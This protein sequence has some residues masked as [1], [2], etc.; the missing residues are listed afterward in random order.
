MAFIRAHTCNLSMGE[1]EQKDQ[2]VKDGFG[3]HREIS[4]Q[5]KAKRHSGAGMMAQ[6]VFQRT[7]VQFPAP[8]W[9]IS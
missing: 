7:K 9:G 3:S 8:T 6:L 5:N 4:S 1:A 2:D